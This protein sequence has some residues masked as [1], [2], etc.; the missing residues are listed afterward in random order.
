ASGWGTCLP[1]LVSGR[2]E[3]ENPGGRL[4]CPGCGSPLL[5]ARA[6]LLALPGAGSPLV[7]R[8]TL[9]PESFCAT[10]LDPPAAR[11]AAS[12]ALAPA[13]LRGGIA[14]GPRRPRRAAGR[15]TVPL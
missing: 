11:L 2:L 7:R 10:A 9:H 3:A 1:D 14:A 5:G 12:A 4:R 6:S 15:G 8:G 13:G